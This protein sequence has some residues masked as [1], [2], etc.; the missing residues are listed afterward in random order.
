MNNTNPLYKNNPNLSLR[1]LGIIKVKNT[2]VMKSVFHIG[3]IQKIIPSVPVQLFFKSVA[4]EVFHTAVPILE[5]SIDWHNMEF[6]S[7]ECLDAETGLIARAM[8]ARGCL[9]F[10]NDCSLRRVGNLDQRCVPGQL[11][12]KF[13]SPLMEGRF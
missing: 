1:D 7:G 6:V 3:L 11:R 8:P 13:I 4:S 12:G 5:Y 9:D 2:D 10:W